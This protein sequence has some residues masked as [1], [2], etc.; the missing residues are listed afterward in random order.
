MLNIVFVDADTL[1]ENGEL[2]F[3]EKLGNITKYGHL[4]ENEVSEKV[5]DAD[6]IV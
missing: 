4:L 6:I 2:D 3:F 1:G 5:V